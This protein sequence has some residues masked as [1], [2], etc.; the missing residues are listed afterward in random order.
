MK[1]TFVFLELTR[2]IKKYTPEF[3]KY[4]FVLVEPTLEA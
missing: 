4:A 1:F 3:K 2:R